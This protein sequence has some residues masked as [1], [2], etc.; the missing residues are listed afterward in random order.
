MVLFCPNSG[1]SDELFDR[2]DLPEAHV[3]V[4][5]TGSGATGTATLR[6]S[7]EAQGIPVDWTF[8][9]SAFGSNT[10]DKIGISGAGFEVGRES[11]FHW[12]IE[13]F[14]GLHFC[15]DDH[16]FLSFLDGYFICSS[17]RKLGSYAESNEVASSSMFGF[18][19][20]YKIPNLSNQE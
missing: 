15:I 18:D 10:L 3:G 9:L 1:Y 16:L 6:V 7:A 20:E 17:F 19:S 8:G 2:A 12:V 4:F 13:P 14:L 11:D 5:V